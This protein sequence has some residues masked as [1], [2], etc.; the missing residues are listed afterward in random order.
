MQEPVARLLHARRSD[1]Q[2]GVQKQR[3]A[4]YVAEARLHGARWADVGAA[5]GVTRQAAHERF[6]AASR[7]HRHAVRS[8]LPVLSNT[9][10]GEARDV[11]R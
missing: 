1:D 8:S 7:R 10:K 2:A 11:R 6:S 3:A 5:F 4:A 9:T